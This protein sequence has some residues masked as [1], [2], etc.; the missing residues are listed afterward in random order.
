VN[1]VILG[2]GK[3]KSPKVKPAKDAKEL[4]EKFVKINDNMVDLELEFLESEIV[5]EWFRNKKA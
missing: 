2:Y 1:K 5:L 3:F 4:Y